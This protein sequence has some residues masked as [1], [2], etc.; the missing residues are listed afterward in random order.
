M[1]SKT[2][3]KLKWNLF[4]KLQVTDRGAA[5]SKAFIYGLFSK[6]EWLKIACSQLDNSI[7]EKVTQG[8]R[9]ADIQSHLHC[10]SRDIVDCIGGAVDICGVATRAE[11]V[12]LLKREGYLAA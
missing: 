7:L 11:L 8:W 12:R 5:I 9:D 1:G 3:N 4:E 10:T 2:F 6:V